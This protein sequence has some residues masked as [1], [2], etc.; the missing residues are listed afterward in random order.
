WLVANCA[1][2][3][4]TSLR[5]WSAY[6]FGPGITDGV[7]FGQEYFTSPSPGTVYL[8][9]TATGALP[10]NDYISRWDIDI[11]NAFSQYGGIYV[12]GPKKIGQ[13]DTPTVYESGDHI[14]FQFNPTAD[15]AH[16]FGSGE[17]A[18]F[19]LYDGNSILTANSFP[20]SPGYPI[21]PQSDTFH[22]LGPGAD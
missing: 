6:P 18:T 10:S 19:T 21:I 16:G 13:F 1:M 7:V 9:L 12:F 22:V 2:A 11:P 15:N 8:T 5:F 3:D 17:S 20:R 4:T 14:Y